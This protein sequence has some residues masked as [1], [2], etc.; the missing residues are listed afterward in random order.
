MATF[1]KDQFDEIPADLARVGAHRAPRKRRGGV[2]FA[3][4]ALATGVLV[5]AGLF[6]LSLVFPS[7][8][9][10]LPSFGSDPVA[11]DTPAPE[12]TAV[13]EP[14]APTTLDPINTAQP[15]S[16]S[17]FN[18]SAVEGLQNTA[19]DAIQAAGWSNP[20]RA[21]AVERTETETVLYYRSAEYEPI[22]VALL[23]LLGTGRVQ[24]SDAYPGAPVTIVLGEDYATVAG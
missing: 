18:G 5:V 17:V 1:P 3:W 19:G 7:I 9:L 10:E 20:A 15:L 13:V 6:G 23:Q 2:I 24:L 14:A 16:L 4:A 21:N 12:E 8:N 22:A 11:S